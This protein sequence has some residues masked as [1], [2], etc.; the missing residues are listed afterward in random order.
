MNSK[1]IDPQSFRNGFLKL[2]T[3]GFLENDQ[4]IIEQE[5]GS[6]RYIE[7]IEK[8]GE[9]VKIAYD[10]L[11]ALL[12]LAPIYADW[13]TYM[14][15]YEKRTYENMDFNK[16]MDGKVIPLS[17]KQAFEM[18]I[19][20]DDASIYAAI[21]DLGIND[22]S[23]T[24]DLFNKIKEGN[25]DNYLDIIVT[26]NLST[27]KLNVNLRILAAIINMDI[28]SRRMF[29][30]FDKYIENVTPRSPLSI[31]KYKMIEDRSSA[32]SNFRDNEETLINLE[33][34]G[35]YEDWFDLII[36][37]GTNNLS[38]IKTEL[39]DIKEKYSTKLNFYS[40]HMLEI[41]NSPYF[42][43]I[44]KYGTI[45]DIKESYDA[46][47][48]SEKSVSSCVEFLIEQNNIGS[49]KDDEIKVEKA[50]SPMI[51]VNKLKALKEKR[52]LDFP[53]RLVNNSEPNRIFVDEH[54][55]ILTEIYN[56]YG[57]GF[58][59]MTCEEFLYLFGATKE[60]PFNYDP[61]Y[62][63]SGDHSTMKALIR[64]LYSPQPKILKSL[65]LHSSD[66]ELGVKSHDWGRN[67]NKVAYVDIETNI[68][69][70]IKRVTG[71]ILKK[72]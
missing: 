42:N 15:F 37:Y 58:E 51:E 55:P 14:Y 36:V 3:F 20:F 67:K 38:L 39:K 6:Q 16:Y 25:Y 43:I 24:F 28:K 1:S 56:L 66:K 7:D 32:Y 69:D 71:K 70:I 72:L 60:P 59:K 21:A 31:K 65:I 44:E 9:K 48:K 61:P 19:N 8:Y 30:E 50:M 22:I 49:A 47:L 68:I 40:K 33:E 27:L 12:N 17:N 23:L 63:W 29:E 57:G 41:E 53:S 4:R 46:Y 18:L 11:I 10:I 2:F 62:Y 64:I 26:N 34:S 35:K 52:H 13:V 54:I 5:V 45:L